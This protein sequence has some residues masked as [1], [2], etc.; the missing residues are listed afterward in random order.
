MSSNNLNDSKSHVH[1]LFE[2]IAPKYDMMNDLMSFGLHKVWRKKT[3]KKMN[4]QK[5]QTALDLCCGT[6]DWTIDLAKASE[7]GHI[8]GLDFSE[9]MLEVGRQKVAEAGLNK[10]IKLV[11]GNAMELPFEDNSFDYV[12]IGFGLRNVP[13]YEQVVA[14]ML[15]VVKPGGQIVCLEMSKPQQQPFKSIYYFYFE[16]MVPLL[17]K[18]FAKQFAAYKWLPDSLKL[19]MD[20]KELRQLFE[21]VGAVNVVVKN[22]FWGIA[23]LHIGR[24]S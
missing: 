3:M 16:K 5:G 2:T 6:C 4:V 24:K 22:F 1:E 17:G 21:K 18:M 12:T 23:A 14:E 8:I 9:Q 13:D 19:F 20:A 11:Q 15:R 10:Q 7:T